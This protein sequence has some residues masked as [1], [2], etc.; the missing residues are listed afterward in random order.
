MDQ[1]FKVKEL[2]A[3]LKDCNP[4]SDI[5]LRFE[6]MRFAVIGIDYNPTRKQSKDAFTIYVKPMTKIIHD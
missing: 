5:I 3:S 6:D 2:M 1:H 4:D